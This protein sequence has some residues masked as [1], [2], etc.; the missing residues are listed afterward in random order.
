MT[1]CKLFKYI[2]LLFGSISSQK[3]LQARPPAHLQHQKSRPLF[4]RPTAQNIPGAPPSSPSSCQ[5]C[6]KRFHI[7][8][9]NIGCQLLGPNSRIM[10]GPGVPGVHCLTRQSLIARRPP[11]SKRSKEDG[12]APL[13][14]RQWPIQHFSSDLRWTQIWS[15]P[16]ASF[17]A[18]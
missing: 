14:A 6:L 10:E 15:E 8:S 11:V 13:C 12:S 5:F 17:A 3:G 16:P 1:A 18:A 4:H 2:S 9:R 7:M